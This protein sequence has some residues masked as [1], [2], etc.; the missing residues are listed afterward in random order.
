MLV[1]DSRMLQMTRVGNLRLLL[2]E[3]MT[4]ADEVDSQAK[5]AMNPYM[6]VLQS[7]VKRGK[8]DEDEVMEGDR[9]HGQTSRP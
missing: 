1:Q 9:Q 3:V 5:Q 8:D 7:C 6:Y 4:T 2:P